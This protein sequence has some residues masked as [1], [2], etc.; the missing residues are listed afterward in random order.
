[1]LTAAA[2]MLA[3][4]N[5][6]S[7]FPFI[8][9]P[10]TAD[11]LLLC[12]QRRT[13]RRRR[14]ARTLTRLRRLCEDRQLVGAVSPIGGTEELICLLGGGVLF[15]L[16]LDELGGLIGIVIEVIPQSL[17]RDLADPRVVILF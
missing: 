11:P 6:T 3:L 12:R 13:R 5:I 17:T 7:P 15:Q 2:T 10:P 8:A 16:P 14:R 1:M 4:P 9:L